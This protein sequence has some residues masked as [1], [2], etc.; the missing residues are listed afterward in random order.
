[1]QWLH[2]L[3]AMREEPMVEADELVYRSLAVEITNVWTLSWRGVM[4]GQANLFALFLLF[5]LFLSYFI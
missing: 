2:E 4:S 5:T 3:S 1:M